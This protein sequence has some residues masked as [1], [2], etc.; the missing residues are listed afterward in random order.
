MTTEL[1]EEDIE[2]IRLTHPHNF[3]EHLARVRR[4]LKAAQPGNAAW[5]ILES[6]YGFCPDYQPADEGMHWSDNEQ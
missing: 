1:Y 2:R 5:V 6:E 4:L 3:A